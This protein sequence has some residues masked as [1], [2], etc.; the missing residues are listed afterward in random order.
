MASGGVIERGLLVTPN[1]RCTFKTAEHLCGIHEAG[2]P[3]GCAASPFTLNKS[4]TLIVRNR[5]RMLKCYRAEGAIPAYLAH[6]RSLA[7][8]LGPEVAAQL[9]THLDSSGGDIRA[10]IDP[11]IL[12]M[13]ETNDAI[14]RAVKETL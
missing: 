9:T 11:D 5:Y 2:Q 10:L 1:K 12:G 13:L 3:F 14:K 8:I 7:A 6:G 4:R